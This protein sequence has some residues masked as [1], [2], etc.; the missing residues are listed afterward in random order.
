MSKILSKK[1]LQVSFRPFTNYP[2]NIDFII[3]INPNPNPNIK[4]E[5]YYNIEY[6]FKLNTIHT[7]YVYSCS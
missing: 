3:N 6:S 2:N 7:Q 1:A 4:I 5:I